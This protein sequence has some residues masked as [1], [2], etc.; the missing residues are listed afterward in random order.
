MNE[1]EIFLSAI[2][3]QD[4]EARKAHVLAACGDDTDLQKRVDALL[5]SHDDHSR[6]LEAPV[7]EQMVQPSAAETAAT[8]M[9][10]NSS[11]PEQQ[12]ETEVFS[13][14]GVAD[15]KKPGET[16]TDDIHLSFLEASSKPDSIGRLAHYEIQEVIGRG[17]FGIVL[18]AFDGKLHRVVAI[19][20][21]A[22]EMAATSPARKRF[23]REARSSAAVRHENVVSIYAVEDQPIPY[24]VME[25]IPGQTLQQRLD[26][27]GPL[28][29]EDVLRIGKQ[30]A[31]G[32]AAAHDQQLIHRDIKPGNILLET[33]VND[34]VKITD[35]G[36]ARTADDASM[37][38]SGMIAG[39]PLYMAP[40]QVQGQK[41]DHRADLFSLG[42]VLYQMLSGRP[43]F[44]APNTIAVLK[45]VVDDTPRPIKDI[46][47][48]VPEW[49]CELIG[50]L[51]AKNP[52]ERYG[53]AKQVSDV[54]AQCVVDLQ[55]GRQ[56]QIPAPPTAE[57]VLRPAL[58][59]QS[60]DTP[61]GRGRSL[62]RVALVA[63]VLLVGLGLTEL[64]G[65]TTLVS[66]ING[67]AMSSDTLVVDVDAPDATVTVDGDVLT[68]LAS[69]TPTRPEPIDWPANAP[70]LA[71]AP[72]DAKQAKQDQQ[73]WADYLGVPVEKDVVLGRDK[74]GKDVTL[75]MVLIPPGEFIIGAYDNEQVKWL[76]EAKAEHPNAKADAF[77]TI[78][79]EDHSFKRVTKPFWLSKLEFKTGQFRRFVESTGYQTDAERN[80]QGAARPAPDKPFERLPELNWDNWGKISVDAGPVVNVSWNDAAKCCEWLSSQHPDMAFSLPT[81]AQ[82]EFACRAGTRNSLYDCETSDELR[83]Y[84]QFGNEVLFIQ[85]GGQLRSNAFGLYDTLGNVT[86]WCSDWPGR[87]DKSQTD[88]PAGPSEPGKNVMKAVRGGSFIHSLWKVR[89]TKRDFYAPDNCF[90]DRGFRVA[91]AIPGGT[92]K[93][94]AKVTSSDAE[95]SGDD[96]PPAEHEFAS[97]EWID[98]IPLIDPE[99][100]PRG[101]GKLTGR[102]EW[103]IENGELLVGSADDKPSKLV[104]PLDADWAAFEFDLELTRRTGQAGFSINIP[105]KQRDCPLIF[106]WPDRAGLM[107]GN[108]RQPETILEESLF[109]TGTKTSLRFIV[110]RSDPD[111]VTLWRDDELVAEWTGDCQKHALDLDEGYPQQRQSSIFAGGRSEFI[112]HR[113]R[114]RMLDGGTATTLRPLNSEQPQEQQ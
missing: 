45:R 89:S 42:S 2:E 80:G 77:V 65:V 14:A 51:H 1:Q 41:L 10:E 31:D 33:S 103:R 71:I 44:R 28:R 112:F 49:M 106:N 54:L 11:S 57:T 74:D 21:L 61:P 85:R 56:P 36:L 15:L 3:I 108:L 91:A 86:E 26:G 27:T 102:N 68:I 109:E 38:Q 98:V 35:F 6:F 70:P 8:I 60:R 84:A 58:S 72:F 62:G 50:H 63:L 43:P 18:K 37:T 59:R 111:Q 73:A 100:D 9:C 30:I 47:P 23:L 87:Y 76:S 55:N 92:A 104:F 94:K 113:F 88:D 90:F 16:T 107:I 97:D 67:M 19:K 81:E 93:A 114:V 78:N 12:R 24:L 52:D 96:S 95:Q 17:A 101:V 82:W 40:E 83:Q 64:T 34:H 22:P 53:T 79:M 5:D 75:T 99:I 69:Q 25:Y 13:K 110:R 48:E 4:P 66:T 46:I 32:L 7:V 105:T 39:T 20:V 29:F